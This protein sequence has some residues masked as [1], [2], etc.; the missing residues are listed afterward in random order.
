MVHDN[1]PKVS[2]DIK[3]W[4]LSLASSSRYLEGTDQA[5]EQDE[6]EEDQVGETLDNSQE[7]IDV[8][9]ESLLEEEFF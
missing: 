7:E 2:N 9:S 5:E 8:A 6:D 4:K 3:N 1:L